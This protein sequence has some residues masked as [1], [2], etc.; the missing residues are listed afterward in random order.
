MV[1]LNI[2]LSLEQHADCSNRVLNFRHF[3]FLPEAS[4]Y[5]LFIG[6]FNMPDINRSTLTVYSVISN[7]FC[8]LISQ[9]NPSTNKLN[10][11]NT[12]H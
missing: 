2:R 8:E 4:G 3:D 6:D 7:I 11:S 10:R 1:N 5:G 12:L 9:S